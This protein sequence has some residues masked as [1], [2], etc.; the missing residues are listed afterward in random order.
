[1]EN[2]FGSLH[3]N[4]IGPQLKKEF[5]CTVAKLAIDGGF[6]CPNRDG[7]RGTGGCTFCSEGG[8]SYEAADIKKQMEA[9]SIKWPGC[10]YMAYFQN[11]SNTYASPEALRQKYNETLAHPGVMG[12]AIATRPDCL[13]DDVLEVLKE[14][15]QKTYLWIELGLQTSNDSTA[16]LINRSYPLHTFDDAMVKLQKAGIKTVVHLIF[17]LPGESRQDMMDSV[18]YVSRLKPFG[19]KFHHL[20]LMEGSQ[21]SKNPPPDLKLL[22]KDEYIRLLVDSIEMLHPDI[23]VHRLGGDPPSNGLI[24]PL[25]SL[26]KRSVLNSVQMEFKRRGSFQGSNFK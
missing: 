20:Y 5:G 8:S 15:N 11:Y 14:L 22:E 3:Y 19:V 18:K 2:L 6:T 12:L 21:L 17:G 13:P 10:K 26:H 9:L 7:T 24:A 4:A 23:T 1:M 16:E 25:W